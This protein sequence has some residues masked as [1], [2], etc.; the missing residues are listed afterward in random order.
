[1]ST[2]RY[3]DYQG[4]VDFEDNK[5]VIRVL[6]IDDL[7]TTEVESAADVEAAFAE[8]VED[9]L[10]TCAEVGKEPA[11]PFKG[12]FNVRVPPDLHRQAAFAAARN[13]VTL[14]SFVTTALEEKLNP[15]PPSQE[16]EPHEFAFEGYLRLGLVTCPVRLR[17]ATDDGPGL[18]LDY[19]VTIE[20]ES[21]AKSGDIEPVYCAG[22]FYLVPEGRIGH[23]AY[24]V[25]REA[26]AANKVIGIAT[27]GRHTF[28]IEPLGV[29][30][31]ATLLRK[32][33]QVRDPS[34]LLDTI[35]NAKVTKEMLALATHIVEKMRAPFDPRKLKAEPK[36]RR[37][38]SEEQPKLA[39]QRG[40]NVI[41]LKEALRKMMRRE[42]APAKDDVA[43]R[44]KA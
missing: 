8:L 30:M 7:I 36:P 23:D 34:E 11:R 35:S 41:D 27:L 44:R 39:L 18:E 14:N 37:T 6:H 10:A 1:M 4:S 31:V 2:V 21:F 16:N 13:E 9:Y 5:L 20:I 40:D 3:R 22:S 24:A 32:A 33:D 17:P 15:P 38:T 25:I 26:M 28:A 42:R 29:G 12:L 19:D 43:P